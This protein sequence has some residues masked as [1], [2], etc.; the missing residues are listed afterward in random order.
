LARAVVDAGV[1]LLVVAGGD[2]TARDVLDAGVSEATVVV[3]VPCG[4]KMFSAVFARSAAVAGDLARARLERRAGIDVR[5]LE[6]MDATGPDDEREVR[7]FGYLTGPFRAGSGLR[8]KAP[9]PPDDTEAV[10]RAAAM[11]AAEATKGGTWLVGPGHAGLAF[12]RALGLQGSL[13]GIDIVADGRVVV[14]DATFRDVERHADGATVLLGVVGGQGYLLGRGN[15]QLTPAALRAASRL[16]VVCGPQKL[17]ELP[18]RALLVDTGD[19]NLDDQLR[20]YVRVL[21]GSRTST[22]VPVR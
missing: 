4:V 3:G 15:Q 14:R 5:P 1:D 20:G 7:L 16:V 18:D 9:A 13:L 21:T 17:A 8:G 19:V 6:V 10:S 22:V 12:L 2:G 11:L